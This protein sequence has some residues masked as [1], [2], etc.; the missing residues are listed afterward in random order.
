MI[1]VPTRT[2]HML[3]QGHLGN[4]E[5]KDRYL[6]AKEMNR[7]WYEG[8]LGAGKGEKAITIIWS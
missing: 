7:R 3:K 1:S 2:E 6:G 5:R 8:N 4:I